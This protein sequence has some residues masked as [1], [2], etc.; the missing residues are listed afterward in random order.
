MDQGPERVSGSGLLVKAGR[1]LFGRRRPVFGFLPIDLKVVGGA[2]EGGLLIL[3][4]VD[5]REGGPPKHVHPSQDEWFYVIVGDYVVEVGEERFTLG[6]GDSVLAPRGVPHVWAHVGAGLGRMLVGFHPAGE[7][8][9]FFA[10]ATQLAGIP[11]GPELGELFAEHGMQ[12][13]GPP[14]KV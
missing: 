8:E 9:A 3:E 2:T 14:L 12:L 13:L 10:R 1:D 5:E 4:Q 11:P 6:P 7:M